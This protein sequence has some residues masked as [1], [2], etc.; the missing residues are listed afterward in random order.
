M[1]KNIKIKAIILLIKEKIKMIIQIIII[2]T[3]VHQL[4]MGI[5]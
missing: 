2:M 3:V 1:N 4:L 5:Y